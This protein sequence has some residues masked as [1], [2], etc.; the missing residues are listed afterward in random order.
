MELGWMQWQGRLPYR[1]VKPKQ[2]MRVSW[3]CLA[4][5]PVRVIFHTS[6]RRTA[7]YMA[8]D[9]KNEHR[10]NPKRLRREAF[11][12]LQGSSGKPFSNSERGNRDH[13][14][15]CLFWGVSLSDE[16]TPPSYFTM[17]KIPQGILL[18]WKYGVSGGL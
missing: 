11:L 10:K 12:W 3:E 15:L 18:L 7:A 14:K 1:P 6:G 13:L 5:K 9:A 17:S 2:L 4:E 16:L 8:A